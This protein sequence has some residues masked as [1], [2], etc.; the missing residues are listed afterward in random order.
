MQKL[1]DRVGHAVPVGQVADEANGDFAAGQ[2]GPVDAGDDQE[3]RL[4]VRFAGG[5]GDGP[6][7][8]SAWAATVGFQLHDVGV[9]LGDRLQLADHALVV[10]ILRPG[11]GDARLR[12]GDSDE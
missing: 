3:G 12:D 2:V 7:V 4:L 11:L 1:G 10:A 9:G 6:D 5:E 8:V